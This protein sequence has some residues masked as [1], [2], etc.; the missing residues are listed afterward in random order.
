MS[1]AALIE[2]L[3]NEDLQECLKRA[4][5]EGISPPPTSPVEN[6]EDGLIF[7]SEAEE[8][9]P[10]GD[11][12]QAMRISQDLRNLLKASTINRHSQVPFFA[13][14]RKN[15]KKTTFLD[16]ISKFLFNLG[17]PEKYEPIFTDDLLPS[18]IRKVKSSDPL[19]PSHQRLK[20]AKA[21]S[22]NQLSSKGLT[23]SVEE[24]AKVERVVEETV[25]D[26]EVILNYKYRECMRQAKTMV[27]LS[28]AQLKMLLDSSQ[29]PV[30][31]NVR[32]GVGD[33]GLYLI[34]LNE[35][36][37]DFLLKG[38][39]VK[40]SIGRNDTKMFVCKSR[41]VSRHQCQIFNDLNKVRKRLI[42]GE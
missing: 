16:K 3:T 21:L 29:L 40:L 15:E 12:E 14:E 42:N 28:F 8:P 18:R 31:L 26:K 24:L 41:V 17:E 33:L 2:H 35:L 23:S 1:D 22:A 9:I 39:R 13:P 32:S 19:L 37:K 7:D 36:G 34:P 10:F 5:Y 11:E 38:K 30:D 27:N 6:G 20:I 4:S 25:V